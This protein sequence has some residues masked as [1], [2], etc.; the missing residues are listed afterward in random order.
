MATRYTVNGQEMSE[1]EFKNFTN[2][3]NAFGNSG[4]WN[5]QDRRNQRR[6]DH[7]PHLYQCYKNTPNGLWNEI[8][9]NEFKKDI[10]NY[11]KF[12]KDFW[13]VQMINNEYIIQQSPVVAIFYD[14][15][16]N[17][18]LYMK[19][20]GVIAEH[21]CFE[22]SDDAMAAIK[23]LEKEKCG[24]HKLFSTDGQLIMTWKPTFDNDSSIENMTE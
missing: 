5:F 8:S 21:N 16:K 20:D 7:K 4:F 14:H 13:Y 17:I 11:P 23:D 1:E 3:A 19:Y 15:V 10:N 6:W 24:E 9:F 18:F 12:L 2:G 22:S